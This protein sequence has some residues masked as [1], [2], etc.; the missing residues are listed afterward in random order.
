VVNITGRNLANQITLT[1]SDALS[2]KVNMNPGI[3]SGTIADW[4][5]AA[6]LPSGPWY[7]WVYPSGWI[8][9]GNQISVAY[10]GP[11]ATLS[12]V[13]VLQASSLAEG[14]YS[15]YFGF[16]TNTNG[17]IDL[18][19]STYS[20]LTVTVSSSSPATPTIRIPLYAIGN[21]PGRAGL[22]MT[23]SATVSGTSSG[24][25]TSYVSTPAQIIV[26]TGS[27]DLNLPST[28]FNFPNNALPAY[29]TNSPKYCI[30]Y[31]GFS[32]SGYTISNAT[33]TLGTANN[34][35]QSMT[36]NSAPV[37]IIDQKCSGACANPTSCSP[38]NVGYGIIG[39]NYN[40]AQS[41]NVLSSNVFR[42]ATAPYNTGFT[43][44]T[45]APIPTTAA[46]LASASA[47]TPIGSL[48]L[49]NLT[50][51]SYNVVQ[52]AQQ[53]GSIFGSGA[54]PAGS[55]S[56]VWN[57]R[58]PGACVTIGDSIYNTATTTVTG[59]LGPTTCQAEV[60]VD[61]GG[62]NGFIDFP[63]ALPTGVSPTGNTVLGVQIPA[64]FTYSYGAPFPPINANNGSN[65]LL[66]A[67]TGFAFFNDY[68]V[69]FNPLSGQMGFLGK[70]LA[71]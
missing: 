66:V 36:I 52:M 67:N 46:A 37:N 19:A 16:D 31:E 11:L 44:T 13:E 63:G 14:V 17:S 6:R 7:S 34:P 55:P 47:T 69:Y 27:A 68:D 56:G 12:P 26:D 43:I 59:P 4:W 15:L 64:T 3:L 22:Y 9:S 45:T 61:S 71:P 54:L 38:G 20:A 51:A 30:T 58:L 62:V 21:E 25:P 65:P 33:V 23:V 18:Q 2:I 49:G 10:Q 29:V 5:L 28:F 42:W 60:V 48:N 40:D 57:S 39:V 53:A 32:L 41:S 8:N 1:P 24:V 50:P 35:G 70:S